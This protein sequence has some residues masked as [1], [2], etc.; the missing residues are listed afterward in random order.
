MITPEDTGQKIT[1][2]EGK[3]KLLEPSIAR[4]EKSERSLKKD[5][6]KL[7]Q[8]V[9]RLQTGAPSQPKGRYHTVRGGETLFGIAQKYGTSIS[10]LRGL[11]KL[12]KAQRI[13]P[14]QKLLVAQGANH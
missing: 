3:V 1:R 14:G 2:L 6:N 13:Q 4:L 5:L 7:G 10:K 12:T 11:N 8:Q 9:R